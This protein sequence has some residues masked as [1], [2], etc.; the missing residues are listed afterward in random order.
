MEE[1]GIYVSGYNFTSM[2]EVLEVRSSFRASMELSAQ[3]FGGCLG[4]IGL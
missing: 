1:S 2:S 4:I 3:K